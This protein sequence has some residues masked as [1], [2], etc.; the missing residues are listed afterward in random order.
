MFTG[1]VGMLDFSIY[2][3]FSV[4]ETFAMFLLAFRVFKIDLYIIEII[5]A[6]LIM[7]FVSF[8]L[9]HD[10]SMA[11][12]DVVIQYL[13]TFCFL[14][15]LFRIHAFYATIMTGLMY[16]SYMLL[17]SVCYL[18]MN[19]TGFYSLPFPYTTMGVNILQCISA[20][21]T[22]FISFYINKHRKGFDFVPDKR[23]V[24]VQI[25][26]KEFILFALTLPSLL[27]IIFIFQISRQYSSFYFFLPLAYGALLCA[28]LYLSYKKDRRT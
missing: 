15:L 11:L 7:A 22:I 21:L 3:F 25:N 8:V 16:L 24:R 9:R 2:M 28:Y 20:S 5:F 10:Y 4:L 17:Q 1:S 26:S 6:S 18:I 13:L 19:F 27:I 14:W 12:T 23:S